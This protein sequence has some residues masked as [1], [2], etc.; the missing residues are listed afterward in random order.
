MNRSRD[1][2]IDVIDELNCC[3]LGCDNNYECF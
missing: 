3:D 1:K 2:E